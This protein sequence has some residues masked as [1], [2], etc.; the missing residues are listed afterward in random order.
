MLVGLQKQLELHPTGCLQVPC[1]EDFQ[2]ELLS[3]SVLSEVCSMSVHG[4]G[5]AG[6]SSCSASIPVC[7]MEGRCCSILK[8][9][10]P[11]A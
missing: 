9:Q 6:K 3:S 8:P 7:Q 10:C 11:G 4:P 5:E 2:A 1:R